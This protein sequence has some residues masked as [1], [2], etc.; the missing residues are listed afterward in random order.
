M[1]ESL[2][3]SFY[4]YQGPNLVMS[5]YETTPKETREPVNVTRLDKNDSMKDRVARQVLKNCARNLRDV[6]DSVTMV[7][8]KAT[9][10]L[11]DL[12]EAAN[13]L[14]FPEYKHLARRGKKEPYRLADGGIRCTVGDFRFMLGDRLP[15]GEEMMVD[16]VIPQEMPAFLKETE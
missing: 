1:E 13:A 4:F 8:P 2:G 3:G 11:L 5:D 10:I 9:L 16:E 7:L 6:G 14:E 15:T 12:V